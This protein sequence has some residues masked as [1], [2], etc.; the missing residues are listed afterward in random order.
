M[1]WTFFGFENFKNLKLKVITKSKEL[2]NIGCD[3]DI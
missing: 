3:L 1:S 2:H